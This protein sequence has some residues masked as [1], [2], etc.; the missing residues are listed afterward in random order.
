MKAYSRFLIYFA[1]HASNKVVLVFELSSL[2]NQSFSLANRDQ[3]TAESLLEIW[4][5][6]SFQKIFQH[7]FVEYFAIWTGKSEQD[8]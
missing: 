7:C 2:A 1:F 4:I 5:W 6:L 8:P 3:F